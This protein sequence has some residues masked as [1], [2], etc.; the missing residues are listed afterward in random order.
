MMD[1]L[2]IPNILQI[3]VRG[4]DNLQR[5]LIFLSSSQESKAK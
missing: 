2:N 1:D 3:I 5:G 4:T